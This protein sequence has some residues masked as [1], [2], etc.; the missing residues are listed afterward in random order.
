[1]KNYFVTILIASALTI[2]VVIS[3]PLHMDA[4]TEKP[5]P[6]PNGII[7]FDI[8]KLTEDQAAKVREAMQ[9]CMDTGAKIKFIPRT[10]E[11]EYIMRTLTDPAPVTPAM[12]P[13]RNRGVRC[14]RFC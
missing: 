5:L 8:S 4:Q 14:I 12:E 1:M 11:T 10:T 3:D 7:P 6:W 13:R 9:L 2:C